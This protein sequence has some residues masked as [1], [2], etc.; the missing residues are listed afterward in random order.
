MHVSSGVCCTDFGSGVDVGANDADE[1]QAG[2]VHQVIVAVAGVCV[3][4]ENF[5]WCEPVVLQ[6]QWTAIDVPWRGNKSSDQKASKITGY[7]FQGEFARRIFK[8]SFHGKKE[9][10]QGEV[11]RRVFNRG[12]EG[13][14]RGG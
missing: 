7:S 9:C 2:G 4:G 11:S 5:L 14:R 12:R 6:A 13:G 3:A 10:F 8:E 1:G